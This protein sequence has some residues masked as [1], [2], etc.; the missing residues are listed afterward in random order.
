MPTL[1]EQSEKVYLN[2][3]SSTCMLEGFVNLDNH[4]LLT[5]LK[6]PQIFRK[7]IPAKYT[8]TVNNYEI[9]ISKHL[10]MRHDCR[11]PLPFRDNTVDHILCSH[12]LEHV[13]STE[14]D[15]IIS[16]FRRV[17]KPKGTLHIVLPDLL[18][19][20]NKY[21]NS[22]STENPTAADKFIIE[23]LLRRPSQSTLKYRLLEFLGGY[24]LDHKWMYD[25]Y[26][27]TQKVAKLGF[28][29][30]DRNDTPSKSFRDDDDSIHLVAKK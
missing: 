1:M 10:F 29:L 24:G 30:M 14:A 22:A 11:S 7:L 9:L 18:A 20:A 25:K 5:F 13:Y 28:I 15:K 4:V 6:L 12:F 16:D 2:I 23:T 3:A 17:L 8:D 21:V 26:S 19:M 27:I